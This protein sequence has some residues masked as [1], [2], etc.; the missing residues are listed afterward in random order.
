[1]LRPRS[2]QTARANALIPGEGHM[3][4]AAKRTTAQD[5]HDFGELKHAR[6]SALSYAGFQ[7]TT[8]DG[9]PATL[10]VIDKDGNVIESGP[11]VNI[12][13]FNTAITAYRDFLKG[14]GHLRVHSSPP[15]RP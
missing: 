2:A 8:A 9:E 14:L 6:I 5:E 13:A 10:G 7:V 11:S 15:A 4:K 12:A 1:M 3:P